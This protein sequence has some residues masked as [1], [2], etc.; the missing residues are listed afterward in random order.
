MTT[1]APPKRPAPPPPSTKSP[2]AAN[3]ATAP[4]KEFGTE[5]GVRNAPLKVVIYGPGGVGKSEL[6]SLI[7]QVGI[8]PLFIDLGEGTNYLD[9]S[10]VKPAVET[11]DD[12]RHA[13]HTEAIWN[14]YDAIV[15]DDLTKAQEL[16]TDWAVRNIKHEKG[17]HVSSIEGYGFGKGNTHVYETFLRLIGDLDAHTRRGRHVIAIAHECTANV[18]NPKGEDWIRYEPRLQSPESGKNSIRH[19]V[20]EWADHLFFVGYDVMV[21]NDGKAERVSDLVG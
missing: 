2:P 14:G 12:L 10:R 18:P 13:L 15:I 6:C 1:A 7:K 4:R 3:G 19:R 11:W 9:V 21:D 17:H 16:A 5:S 8:N 20:K